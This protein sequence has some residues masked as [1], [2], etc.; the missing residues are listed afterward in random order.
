MIQRVAEG[1]AVPEKD[2][3]GMSYT[4]ELCFDN[5]EELFVRIQSWSEQK[6]HPTLDLMRGKRI[7]VELYIEEA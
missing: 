4:I 7:R 2:D 3:G 1:I 6:N 5:D